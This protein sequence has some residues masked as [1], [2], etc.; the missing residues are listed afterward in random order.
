MFYLYYREIMFLTYLEPLCMRY[1][2]KI[3]HNSFKWNNDGKVFFLRQL[4]FYLFESPHGISSL[5][6][7]SRY[8]HWFQHSDIF[9]DPF[10]NMCT[11]PL[12]SPLYFAANTLS[13]H[14]F[15]RRR[16]IISKGGEEKPPVYLCMHVSPLFDC[17]RQYDIP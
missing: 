1:L 12:S 10:I 4:S 11:L 17:A 13:L 2:L 9:W 3:N 7:N 6:D 14:S 8:M 15:S 5:I 16:P